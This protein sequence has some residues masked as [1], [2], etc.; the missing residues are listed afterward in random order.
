MMAKFE[1]IKKGFTGQNL[2]KIYRLDL[3][4]LGKKLDPNTTDHA[5]YDFEDGQILLSG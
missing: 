3:P 5:R 1:T 2:K 4:A